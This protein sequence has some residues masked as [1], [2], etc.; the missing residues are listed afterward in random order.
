MNPAEMNSFSAPRKAELCSYAR[1]TQTVKSMKEWGQ[2]D[3][4][5]LAVGMYAERQRIYLLIM[6]I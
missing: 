2:S 5:T 1:S 3:G 6:V 4:V